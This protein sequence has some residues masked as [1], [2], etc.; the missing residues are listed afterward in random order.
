MQQLRSKPHVPIF[1]GRP[2]K[3]PGPKPVHLTAVWKQQAR[4]FARYILILLRPWKEVWWKMTGSIQV[5]SRG[6]K[7]AGSFVSYVTEAP[8]RDKHFLDANS[9][10]VRKYRSR[11]KNQQQ[12][13]CSSTRLQ[14]QRIVSAQQTGC[15]ISTSQ[16]CRWMV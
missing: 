9:H 7:C 14:M 3:P 16:T 1:I 13:T 10:Y 12:R 2:P 15:Y 8:E 5:C 11:T 4:R 6:R